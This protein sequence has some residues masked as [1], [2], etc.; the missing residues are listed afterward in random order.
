MFNQMRLVAPLILVNCYYVFCE[1]SPE[2]ATFTP[3]PEPEIEGTPSISKERHL[4]RELFEKF[5]NLEEKYHD[6]GGTVH[7]E[8]IEELRQ[9]YA[10]KKDDLRRAHSKELP[11]EKRCI[12][13]KF[14]QYLKK[15]FLGVDTPP[16]LS[17][18][19]N[20]PYLKTVQFLKQYVCA[21]DKPDPTDEDRKK[22]PFIRS[23]DFVY[24][25][26]NLVVG[27]CV[28]FAFLAC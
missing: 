16:K 28:L 7:P 12:Y 22:C 25:N 15:L 14:T 26:K 17:G 11:P 8:D 18:D 5:E 23:R 19:K 6:K 10:A 24:E 2:I 3:S 4:F 21:N 27:A 20:C 9:F 1:E 13:L